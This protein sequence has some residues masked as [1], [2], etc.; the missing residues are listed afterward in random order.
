MTSHGSTAAASEAEGPPKPAELDALEAEIETIKA[1][2][3]ILRVGAESLHQTDNLHTSDRLCDLPYRV[4]GSKIPAPISRPSAAKTGGGGS[5]RGGV[6]KTQLTTTTSP[7]INNSHFAPTPHSTH[8]SPHFA[9]P[10]QAAT[11]RVHQT[12]RKDASPV[13]ASPELSSNRSTK[14]KAPD[15][16][17]DKRAAQRHQK[18]TSLPPTWTM[19]TPPMSESDALKYH[20]GDLDHTA[21]SE[22]LTMPPP[23]MTG[24]G[25]PSTTNAQPAEQAPSNSTQ[26]NASPA[27]S[28]SAEQS[29]RNPMLRNQTSSYMAPTASAQR[30]SRAA[31]NTADRNARNA[32]LDAKYKKKAD[33]LAEV[34]AMSKSALAAHN[35]EVD[36]EEEEYA[37]RSRRDGFDM[38]QSPPTHYPPYDSKEEAFAMLSHREGFGM[39]PSPLAAYN[40]TAG[41]AE[42]SHA[43]RSRQDGLDMFQSSLAAYN[44][45][46]GYAEASHATRS[47]QERGTTERRPPMDSNDFPGSAMRLPLPLPHVANTVV[48][49]QEQDH[50]LLDP[51]KEKLG[52]ENLL[53]RAP[54]HVQ[55]ATNAHHGSQNDIQNDPITRLVSGLRGQSSANIGM[56]LGGQQPSDPVTSDPAVLY[57]G[58]KPPSTGQ[59][60]TYSGQAPQSSSLRATAMT[61]VPVTELAQIN[62]SQEREP[63]YLAYDH[64]FISGETPTI[65]PVSEVSSGELPVPAVPVEPASTSHLNDVSVGATHAAMPWLN[66]ERPQM[67]EPGFLE[68]H[69]T[70]G[71][72]RDMTAMTDTQAPWVTSEEIARRIAMYERT[73]TLPIAARQTPTFTSMP[74]API[75]AVSS[76]VNLPSTPQWEIQGEGRRSYQWAG[77]DGREITFRGIGPDAEH[78]PNRPVEYRDLRTNTATVLNPRHRGASSISLST[79]LRSMREQAKRMSD[80]QVPRADDQQEGK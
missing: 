55:P 48:T 77:G 31:V 62:T 35:R 25:T 34:M 73:G 65:S 43:T 24:S 50:N 14:A 20:P 78:D 72:S 80:S 52:Q 51:I 38:D 36:A 69:T 39:F 12:L 45:T 22:H 67:L 27:K 30:R 13:K 57:Q 1:D 11:R 41:Y 15:F 59:T 60:S 18:R 23:N 26:E 9:Q 71:S 61:F 10:T 79:A 2:I 4:E 56:A 44:H 70:M 33:E 8:S 29:Q 46:A 76:P 47:H 66:V 40:H 63:S 68:F 37:E 7:N 75:P 16:A 54:V 21:E 74:S 28:S 17:T 6:K 19:S 32:R 49:R 53:R 42:A 3:Q 5:K 64:D 58:P